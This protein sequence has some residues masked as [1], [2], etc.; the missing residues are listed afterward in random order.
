MFFC[1]CQEANILAECMEDGLGIRH[2]TFCVNAY[3]I[4]MKKEILGMSC[5]HK[6]FQKLKPKFS[7]V[8]KMKTGSNKPESEWA[9]A[10]LK[11]CIQLI[12]MF[13]AYESLEDLGLDPDPDNNPDHF[14]PN[15]IKHIKI[16]QVAWWDEH[17]IECLIAASGIVLCEPKSTGIESI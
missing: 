5:I 9:Q 2:A 4:S 14:N 7:V 17:H 16:E 15:K 12:I 6:L 3:R 10:R 1:A 8:G 13:R 11:W